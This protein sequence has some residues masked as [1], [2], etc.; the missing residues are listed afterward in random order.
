MNKKLVTILLAVVGVLFLGMAIYYWVTPA[1][2]LL[3]FVPGYD[4]AS[5]VIHFKHGLAMLI[6]AIGA[7]VL[8]WF[9]SARKPKA[10]SPAST[11]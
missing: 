1:N 7:W 9:Q 2:Q 11:Q 6:L 10:S 3:A 4:P 8:A 5:A